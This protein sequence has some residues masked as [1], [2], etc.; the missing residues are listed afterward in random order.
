M[1]YFSKKEKELFWLDKVNHIEDFIKQSWYD[2]NNIK[3]HSI[4]LEALYNKAE[5]YFN[6]Q[7]N[8]DRQSMSKIEDTLEYLFSNWYKE[9]E[10]TDKYILFNLTNSNAVKI[11]WVRMHNC[12]WWYSNYDKLY[13]L[14]KLDWDVVS[15]FA[16]IE[17]NKQFKWVCNS[18][19]T[20]DNEVSKIKYLEKILNIDE[21]EFKVTLV[22][23][24]LFK[25]ELWEITV[26]YFIF[27]DYAIF[28]DMFI[29]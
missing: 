24:E 2:I 4:T 26:P 16:T 1:E 9:I 19:V 18:N 23:F 7:R 11:E 21:L 8:K 20:L 27:K 5:K 12:V 28:N 14:K 3:E 25:R 10:R 15:D 22:D 6:K 13:S 17:D 29:Y